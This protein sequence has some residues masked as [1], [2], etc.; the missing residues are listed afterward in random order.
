MV[1]SYKT[2]IREVKIM[3]YS[4]QVIETVKEEFEHKRQNA[5][6]SLESRKAEMYGINDIFTVHKLDTIGIQVAFN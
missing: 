3:A 4:K 5:V 6:N 1:K 2:I